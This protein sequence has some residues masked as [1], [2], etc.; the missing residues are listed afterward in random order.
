MRKIFENKTINGIGILLSIMIVF[1]IGALFYARLDIVVGKAVE[2]YKNGSENADLILNNSI[3]IDF[4]LFAGMVLVVSFLAG[5]FI[6]NYVRICIEEKTY[7][8]DKIVEEEH[9]NR[10][11]L[12]GL[13][14]LEMFEFIAK[15]EMELSPDL[16]HAFFLMDINNFTYYNDVLGHVAGDRLL[17]EFADLLRG[18]FRDRDVI[19]R[20]ENDEFIVM[21]N[22]YRKRD[23]LKGLAKRLETAIREKFDVNYEEVGVSM[24]IAEFDNDA[25]E[26]VMFRVKD[27][28]EICKHNA[29]STYEFG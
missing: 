28:L 6:H 1:S 16:N 23:N 22:D 26:K 3:M 29:G 25:Y 2:A 18:V 11:S 10:D 19:S 20:I 21:V 9:T 13:I 7:M 14:N 4:L 8:P 12:T 15:K 5:F 24:G 17:V 27:A